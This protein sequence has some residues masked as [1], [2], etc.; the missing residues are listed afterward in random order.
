MGTG[1]HVMERNS[2]SFVG[3]GFFSAV[4]ACFSFV[5]SKVVTS[6]TSGLSDI[7][8]RNETSFHCKKRDR[9]RTRKLEHG[10]SYLVVAGYPTQMRATATH[11]I[12]QLSGAMLW[13]IVQL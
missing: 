7:L 9:A 5:L 13:S 12:F 2:L 1:D 11:N 6:E 3:R 8:N 4:S 10:T